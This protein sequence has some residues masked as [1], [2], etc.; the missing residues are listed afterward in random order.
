MQTQT[1]PAPAPE[2]RDRAAKRPLFEPAIVRCYLEFFERFDPQIVMQTPGVHFS[3]SRHCR[4]NCN[5][6]AFTAKTIQHCEPAMQQN[7]A[8]R[9]RDAG[10]NSGNLLK[11]FDSLLGKNVGNRPR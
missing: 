3:D 10:P 8:N 6:A 9:A 5:R 11:T 1:P 2:R 7:V 4:E